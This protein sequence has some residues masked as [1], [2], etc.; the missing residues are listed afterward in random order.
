[1]ITNDTGYAAPYTT[2]LDSVLDYPTFYALQSAF[3]SHHGNLSNL[4]SVAQQTQ[5]QYNLSSFC[6][7]SFLENH[8]NPRMQSITQDQ[9][10]VM[11]AIAWNF[12]TDGIPIVY[13]GQEQGFNGSHNPDNRE[14]LWPSAY[15]T[16]KPLVTHI[17]KLNAARKAAYAYSQD[18]HHV[19]M[20]IVGQ[21]NNSL[22]ISKPPM[23]ALLSNAGNTSTP[24]WNISDAGYDANQQLVDVLSCNS[25]QAD[26]SGAVTVTSTNGDPVV[27]LPNSMLVGSGLCGN[28][29]GLKVTNPGSSRS[30]HSATASVVN[31]IVAMVTI[32]V[33]V[34]L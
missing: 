11:N 12:V 15:N 3:S 22:A 31:L 4:A 32:F 33:L 18:F 34:S 30:T 13:Y 27:L 1:V 9:S 20:K 21:S 23:L 16:N 17:T 19:Q 10:L 7:G 8:D 28:S 6:T 24:S 5:Q 25:V 2:V 29:V 26:G 14:A